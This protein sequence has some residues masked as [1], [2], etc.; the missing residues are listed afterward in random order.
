[1]IKRL[2]TLISKIQQLPNDQQERIATVLHNTLDQNLL[3]NTTTSHL[4]NNE[5]IELMESL[6][7]DISNHEDS[8]R[9]PEWHETELKQTEQ[10][11]QSGQEQFIDWDVAKQKLLNQTK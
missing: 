3:I 6:W 7:Q 1:M 8:F 10:R 11:V 9:S 5:K 2:E 4:S